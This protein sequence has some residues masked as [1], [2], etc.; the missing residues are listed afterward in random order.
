[1]PLTSGTWR[2]NVNGRDA[3]LAVGASGPDGSV[4]I[5]AFPTGRRNT[6]GWFATI[7]EVI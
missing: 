6:F 1:M 7:T 5:P 3:E 2:I 4:P